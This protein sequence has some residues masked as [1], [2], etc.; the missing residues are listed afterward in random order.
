M[1]IYNRED[2]RT[3][4][5]QIEKLVEGLEP[6]K[7]VVKIKSGTGQ[8]DFQSA[9]KVGC[10]VFLYVSAINTSSV[11]SGYNVADGVLQN[12]LPLQRTNGASYYG[13]HAINTSILSDG[14]ITVRNASSTSL[15]ANLKCNCTFVYVTG[16]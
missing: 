11:G 1:A 2:S 8:I 7:I 13:A 16:E 6:Q 9:Y 14:T 15:S 5:P 10:I 12:Y 4:L 3:V